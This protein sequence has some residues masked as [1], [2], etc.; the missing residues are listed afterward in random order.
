MIL[1]NIW[2]FNEA[3]IV[4]ITTL[5]V[6]SRPLSA[7]RVPYSVITLVCLLDLCEVQQMKYSHGPIFVRCSEQTE[8]RADGFGCSHKTLD[9]VIRKTPSDSQNLILLIAQSYL[10][11]V[12]LTWHF[13]SK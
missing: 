2:Q 8:R 5:P 6:K 4:N 9:P 13:V 10:I 12:M 1:Q 3:E 7:S 11:T